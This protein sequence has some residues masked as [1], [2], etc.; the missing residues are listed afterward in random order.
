MNCE[1]DLLA[2]TFFYIGIALN[3]KLTDKQSPRSISNGF[4]SLTFMAGATR[5]N[6][7]TSREQKL[8]RNPPVYMSWQVP[9][10]IRILTYMIC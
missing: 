4:F 8:L 6:I 10:Y 2:D 9:V 7:Y 5:N 3:H 1:P